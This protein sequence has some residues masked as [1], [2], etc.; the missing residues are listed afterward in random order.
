MRFF[1]FILLSLTS[2]LALGSCHISISKD[3]S[4]ASTTPID[5]TKGIIIYHSLP[6]GNGNLDNTGRNGYNDPDGKNFAYVVFWASVVNKT[7]TPI[8]LSMNFPVDSFAIS[9]FPKGYVK[10]FLPPGTMTPEKVSEFDYGLTS[11]K[12]FLDA[13][14]YK[15]TQLKK[16]IK[17]NE[18]YRFYIA[19]VSHQGYN[20][21][22]RAELVLK[23]QNLFYKINMLDS[24]LPCGKIVFKK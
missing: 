16:T 11:L 15:T 23:E 7:D 4:I 21:A 19:A 14:F 10:F 20:K 1:F 24:L 5:T 3:F 13:N 6:R 18:E 8:E 2:F 12:S 9:G 17:P 22:V